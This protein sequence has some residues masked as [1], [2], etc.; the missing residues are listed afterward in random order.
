MSKTKEIMLHGKQQEPQEETG[1]KFKFI[2]VENNVPAVQIGYCNATRRYLGIYYTFDDDNR[3]H[4][5]DDLPS[6][7]FM[8]DK[9]WHY[10][11]LLHRDCGPSYIPDSPFT[12]DM[13][14]NKYYLYGIEYNKEFVA[15][16]KKI[17]DKNIRKLKFKYFHI[18]YERIYSNIDSDFVKNQVNDGYDA[19]Y[20]KT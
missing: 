5:K 8:H 15:S 7:Y 18:W 1:R 10:H 17:K 12:K 6:Q 19:L 2:Y 13:D 9:Y 16:Y 3:L 14:P 20:L 11:G 4:S